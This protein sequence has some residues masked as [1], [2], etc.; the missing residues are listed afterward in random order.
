MKHIS[1]LDLA[2]PSQSTVSALEVWR[3]VLDQ[4]VEGATTTRGAKFDFRLTTEHHTRG[5]R[6]QARHNNRA[7]ST[8]SPLKP[9]DP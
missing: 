4:E 2:L 9:I 1:I 8:G 7:L 5:K 6:L 3:P